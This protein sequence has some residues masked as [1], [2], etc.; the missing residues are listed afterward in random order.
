MPTAITEEVSVERR[1]GV[2]AIGV[3]STVSM[4]QRRSVGS[5]MDASQTR[6][7]MNLASGS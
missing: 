6:L 5:L 4:Q 7:R 1:Q 3:V 2:I